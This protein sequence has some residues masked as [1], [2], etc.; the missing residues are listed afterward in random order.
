MFKMMDRVGRR[1]ALVMLMLMVLLAS[2]CGERRAEKLMRAGDIERAASI[3]ER[4]QAAKPE[5]EAALYGLT[6][7]ALL[8]GR[9]E[10]AAAWSDACLR[11]HPDSARCLRVTGMQRQQAGDIEGAR[12]AY[13]KAVEKAPED[14]DVLAAAASFASD[15]EDFARANELMGRV[16]QLSPELGDFRFLSAD[17]AMR[18]GKPDQ[19]LERLDRAMELGFRERRL[20]TNAWLVRGWAHL[21]LAEQAVGAEPLDISSAKAH[22]AAMEAAL[23]RAESMALVFEESIT[24]QAANLRR[25][26]GVLRAQVGARWEQ[27]P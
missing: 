18:E 27:T 25:R 3:Y 19:A 15:R 9:A 8:Q 7:T 21:M 2:A 24:V 6:F 20:E 4:I 12:Q 5:S 17:L 13:D 22:L 11:A 10:D 26:S 1:A 23:T 14:P 16:L